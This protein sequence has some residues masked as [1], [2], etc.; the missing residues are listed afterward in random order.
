MESME[1]GGS[2][3]FWAG[4]GI[5]VIV[6]AAVAYTDSYPAPGLQPQYAEKAGNRCI[7]PQ[8]QS[9]PSGYLQCQGNNAIKCCRN[10]EQC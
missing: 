3:A 4:L 10:P 5:L 9:C 2:G 1:N 6:L 7:E 8:N